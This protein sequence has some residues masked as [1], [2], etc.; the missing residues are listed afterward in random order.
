MASRVFWN[1]MLAH[2]ERSEI[3][4]ASPGPVAGQ[5]L[6]LEQERLSCNPSH[7][8]RAEQFREGNEQMDRQDEP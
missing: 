7:A 5:Q 1:A 6:M 8:S 4:R 3:G 2:E